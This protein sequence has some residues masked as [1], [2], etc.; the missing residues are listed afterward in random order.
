MNT[1]AQTIQQNPLTAF[2]RQPKIFIR[3][4]SAG[5]FWSQDSL[6][7][8][9]NGEYPVYSMTA[10]D[11][12]MLKIPDALMNGQAVVDGIQ[13][14][15]PNIKNA[16]SVPNIDMDVIL[17]AIR[18]ATY[19][20]KL[21][22]PITVGETEME[23]TVDLRS[24]LDSLNSQITWVSHIPVNDD[25]TVFVRPINYKQVTE[26]ANQSFE[27]Q[28]IMQIAND[29]KMPEEEKIALFKESFSKLS[30]VTVGLIAAS[31]YKIDSS[32]GSTENP[33]FIK[34]FIDNSDKEIFNKIQQHIELLKE[35]NSIKPI[36]IPVTDELREQGFV[37]ESV[38]IPLTFDAS[39]FF[40]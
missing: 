33:Q 15:M 1:T 16:W 19:G 26:L 13:H 2:M 22:T 17:I 18:I 24:V 32:N 6:Q 5:E 14:C 8:S 39:A 35:N 34:E 27:T 28:K 40:G 30:K 21:T 36:I 37:G 38:E 9:E 29:D 3:L 20:E 11:E 4:P 12:L 7:V 25:L 23:Y 10:Q 31:I